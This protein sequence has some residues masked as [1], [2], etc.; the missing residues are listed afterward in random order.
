MP[1]ESKGMRILIT[2][3]A[4]FAGHHFVEHFLRHTDWEIVILDKLTYASNGLDRLREIAAIDNPR[5]KVLAAD[6]SSK[7]SDGVVKEIGQVD[8]ILHMGAETH[9]DHSIVDALPFLMTNVI[10]T[11]HML[12]F[13]RQQPRLQKFVYSSTDE[14]FGPAPQMMKFSEWE[15]YNSG[16]PYAASKAGGEELCLAY[17]NTHK[18]PVIITHTMNLFGERQH[19]EK[20]I[21]L[22]VKKIAMGQKITIHA[23]ASKTHAGS[24]FYIHCRNAADAILFLLKSSADIMAYKKFNIVGQKEVDNLKLAQLIAEIMGKPLD[25]EM[26]DFH[27]TRPGHDLRY[28]L[29]GK[30]MKTLGWEPPVDFEKS[31]ERTVRWT[32]ENNRWL[33]WK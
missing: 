31:L 33:F 15:R 5:V 28:A 29:D 13:A 8:Y 23:N 14:V 2:G 7:L 20:F 22:C 1:E 12:E 21:P 11:Y 18:V 25:Y 26:V 24:R 9:V 32:L 27:S 16:N 4:G 6:F 17:A 19:P 3:G 30:L 10:G